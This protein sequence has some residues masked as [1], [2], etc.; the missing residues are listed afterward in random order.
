M[1]CS[2][3]PNL[4]AA[5]VCPSSY[6]ALMWFHV[7]AYRVTGWFREFITDKKVDI[8]REGAVGGQ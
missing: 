6:V 1:S 2:F 4:C 7:S 3:L 8:A 5:F